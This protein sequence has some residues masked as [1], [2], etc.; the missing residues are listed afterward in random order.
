MEGESLLFLL[1]HFPSQSSETTWKVAAKG[2]Y[3]GRTQTDLQYLVFLNAQ[4]MEIA[5]SFSICI[6][7]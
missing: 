5:V 4:S 2:T 7:F 3:F 1:T 6:S